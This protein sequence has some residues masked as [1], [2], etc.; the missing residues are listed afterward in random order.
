LYSTRWCPDCLRTRRWL[1]EHRI[2]FEEIDVDENPRANDLITQYGY[3]RRVLPTL[4]VGGRIYINPKPEELSRIFAV[5]EPTPVEAEVAIIGAGPAGLTAAIYL[6]REGVKT[7]VL[8]KLT[9]G[10]Q[11]ITTNFVE[12]YPGF[13]EGVGGLELM[14]KL[15][16]QAR[17]FGA[18][19]IVPAEVTGI[20][21][22]AGL[23]EL[24]TPP[25]RYR[26]PA[27]IVAA[28]SD[29]RRLDVPGADQLT[30]RGVHYCATCDGPFYRKKTVAVVGGGSSAV[31]ESVFLLNFVDHLYVIQNQ[32]RLTAEQVSVNRLREHANAE[33]LLR[34][35][36]TGVRGARPRRGRSP[37]ATEPLGEGSQ[38][39]SPAPSGQ[40]A[41]E[42]LESVTIRNLDTGEERQLEVAGLFVFIG[43]VPNTRFLAGFLDLDP[44]GYV[45]TKPGSLVTSRPGVFVAGDCRSGSKAQI[46]TAVGDGTVAA[47]F[48]RDYLAER[49]PSLRAARV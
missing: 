3:G 7:L 15:E 27:V 40:A 26:A 35:V 38:E 42:A 47:F 14:E 44:G 37:E 43:Q 21:E 49:A 31:D 34:H 46:T 1:T 12:N 2:D 33:V 6:A 16:H 28:G 9:P 18:Q 29:Y 13:P 11:V 45:V 17:R 19:I 10:G 25:A 8:E 36:V 39:G 30:G 20:D 41:P 5:P 4:D 24:E 23:Y 48:V 22:R 32:D